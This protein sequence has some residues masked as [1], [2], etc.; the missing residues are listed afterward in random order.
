[1]KLDPE[2]LSF[3]VIF[4]VS[5]LAHAVPSYDNC[6]PPSVLID[7]PPRATL[8][9][10]NLKSLLKLVGQSAAAVEFHE[11]IKLSAELLFHIIQNLEDRD[12]LMVPFLPRS[13]IENLYAYIRNEKLHC[14]LKPEALIARLISLKD[15]VEDAQ[16]FNSS[17]DEELL[18]EPW[19]QA[20]ESNPEFPEQE[21]TQSAKMFNTN[22]ESEHELR[23]D[24]GP[25]SEQSR[26]ASRGRKIN[27]LPFGGLDCSDEDED[28]ITEPSVRLSP[29]NP[30]TDVGVSHLSRK[31]DSGNNLGIA[32][33]E[34]PNSHQPEIQG[35][36][37]QW[38]ALLPESLQ[39][40]DMQDMQDSK[41]TTHP[42]MPEDGRP[43]RRNNQM[44]IEL[45]DLPLLSDKTI[46]QYVSFDRA[47]KL[48]S[49][50]FEVSNMLTQLLADHTTLK[51]QATDV[52]TL[53]TLRNMWAT[54]DM[55]LRNII[56]KVEQ[57]AS[58]ANF[59]T[60]LQDL[61]PEP[62]RIRL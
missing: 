6:G 52:S 27:P 36:S 15:S 54:D 46:F 18:D 12:G 53:E 10:E 3:V 47:I 48:N 32:D 42:E 29:P 17:L 58:T 21:I 30:P 49:L 62:I 33:D 8:L 26:C 9:T 51:L 44:S 4:S 23:G 7:P 24:S 13:L 5:N 43:S 59:R 31:G 45:P 11:S 34:N 14:F 57:M 35:G 1:M 20:A 41:F 2:F 28:L 55:T 19:P 37:I 22:T 61:A 60:V 16:D 56:S 50:R 40:E 38:H 39:G 25:G